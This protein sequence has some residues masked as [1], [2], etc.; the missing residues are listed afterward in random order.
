ME[1][2]KCHLAPLFVESCEVQQLAD[3]QGLE[4]FSLELARKA[5]YRRLMAIPIRAEAR[6]WGVVIVGWA[7]AGPPQQNS[8]EL[9]QGFANQA[10]I[11][12]E[13]ARLFRKTRERTADVEEALKYQTATSE[14][15]DVI[16]RSPNDLPPV[17]DSILEVSSRIF[18]PE[19]AFGLGCRLNVP[20]EAI[21]CC[22]VKSTSSC[23]FRY[24]RRQASKLGPQR[25]RT[26]R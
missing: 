5:G 14:V 12:I 18:S 10:S 4:Y 7:E 24:P 25:I 13:N 21:R 8:V 26:Y 23:I 9:V 17:L 6:F 15:L 19:Y 1:A 16:S 22:V 2:S 11:A 20:L 3:A